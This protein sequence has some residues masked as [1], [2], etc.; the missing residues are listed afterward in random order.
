MSI[1]RDAT[2]RFGFFKGLHQVAFEGIAEGE[3]EDG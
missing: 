2:A 3:G 1:L